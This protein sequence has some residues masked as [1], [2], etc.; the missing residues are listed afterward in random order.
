MYFLKNLRFIFPLEMTIRRMRG[1]NFTAN[2]IH[3]GQI[4]AMILEHI[5]A[6]A[7]GLQV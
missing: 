5:E 2:M 6:L 7:A 4:K 3:A 1:L